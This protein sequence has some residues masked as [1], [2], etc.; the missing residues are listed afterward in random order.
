MDGCEQRIEVIVK[1]QEKVRG[2]G[3]RSGKWE[4]GRVDVNQELKL[5]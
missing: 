2:G 4:G 1:M 3:V 5:L